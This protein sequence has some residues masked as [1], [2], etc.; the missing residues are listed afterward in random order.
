MMQELKRLLTVAMVTPAMMVLAGLGQAFAGEPL[1]WQ[2]GMQPPVSPTAE[3]LQ[4]LH[5]GLIYL[6][7]AIAL[8]VLALLLYVILKFNHK[9][10]PKP[11]KV[12]HNTLIEVLWT[13]APVLILVVLAVPSLR[14]LYYIDRTH[15]PEMTLKVTGHQ[16]YWSYEYPDQ[17]GFTFDS[18]LVQD[19]DLKPGEPRLLTVDNRMVIPVDTNIRI[20]VTS[21]DVMHSFFFPAG[22]VQT[23]AFPGRTNE[24]WVKVTVPGQYY[25]QCNQICGV[26]HGYMPI[27]IEAVSKEKF[28]EW[29]GK[30]K[31]KFASGD[32]AAPALTLASAGAQ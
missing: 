14:L 29:A 10:N 15:E 24:T 22:A 5:N 3:R 32:A 26:N 18:N 1:N 11:S 2:M 28:A 4:S 9:A 8:F 30:A 19:A 7:F 13:V 21:S 27:S 16:W 6:I 20:L 17:G 31:Q 12:S 25:G 23:Y